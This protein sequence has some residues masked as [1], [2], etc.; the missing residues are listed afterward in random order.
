MSAGGYSWYTSG[1]ITVPSNQ[2]YKI[3]HGS[4]YGVGNSSTYVGGSIRVGR[5][6][7]SDSSPT[8]VWLSSGTYTVSL[9]FGS[10][11]DYLYGSLS[12]VVFN[13]E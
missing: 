8:T 5:H 13:I 9:Y 10:S 2:T 12:V 1:S 11:I 4:C 7:I 6:V 3:T